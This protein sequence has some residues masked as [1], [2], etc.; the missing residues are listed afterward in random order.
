MLKNKKTLI[1]ILIMTVILIFAF[2]NITFGKDIDVDKYNPDIKLDNPLDD[3]TRKIIGSILGI[4]TSIGSVAAVLF[5]I[6]IGIRFVLG[7]AEEKAQYKESLKP[8]LVGAFLL[9]GILQ[10][11]NVL[12]NVGVGLVT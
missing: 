1:F 4:I 3:T 5:L 11:V 12:Y 9:F 6:I 7:S 2:Q 8:Y 10:V